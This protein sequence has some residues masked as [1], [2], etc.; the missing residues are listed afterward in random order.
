MAHHSSE[1]ETDRNGS[2]EHRGRGNRV[3]RSVT[4]LVCE[5]NE[6]HAPAGNSLLGEPDLIVELQ[7]THRELG[8]FPPAIDAASRKRAGR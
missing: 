6:P 8:R 3:P 4:E 5:P 7:L 1:N 2:S